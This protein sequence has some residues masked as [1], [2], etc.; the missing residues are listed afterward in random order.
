MADKATLEKMVEQLKSLSKGEGELCL[1]TVEKIQILINDMSEQLSD[2]DQISGELLTNSEAVI[3]TANYA[4]N[5]MLADKSFASDGIIHEIIEAVGNVAEIQKLIEDSQNEIILN[6]VANDS[7]E[8]PVSVIDE[9]DLPLMEDFI[10]EAAEHIEA[11]EAGLLDIENEPKNIEAINTVFRSFHTLKGLA[12]FLNLV[13]IGKLSHSAENLLDMA[14]NNQLDLTTA[15]MNVIFE[16]VDMIKEMVESVKDAV[17]GD[18]VI[19]PQKNLE[20]MLAKLEACCKGDDIEVEGDTATNTPAVEE[21]Q[22]AV[23]E[24]ISKGSQV[25]PEDLEEVK[26][27]SAVKKSDADEKVKVSTSRLDKLINMVGELVISHSMVE[28]GVGLNSG[29]SGLEVLKKVSHQGKIVRELQEL[30]ML[31]RMVPI[32][33]VFQKMSR[34]VR[35][36]A[37]KSQKKVT[38]VTHGEETELDR[39]LVDQIA[40]PLVHMIRNSVDHGIESEQERAAAG[41]SA[42]GKVTL[43]AFHKGGNIVIEIQDDG[44]G[45]DKDKILAKAKEKGVV[46]S[47]AE[48][49]ESEIYKLIFHAGFST[50]AKVT[51]ISG[52]GVGMDVVKRNIEALRGRIDISSVKGQGTTFT[53][54]LPL[55]MAIIEGQIVRVG[56]EKY[57]IPIVSIL[58]CIRPEVKDVTTVNGKCEMITTQEGLMPL[59]KL[60]DNFNV[61]ADVKKPEESAVVIVESDSKRCGLMVDELLGQKQV[62]I[63]N[64]GKALGKV[65][66]ISGGAIMGDGKVSLILDIAGLMK[67]LAK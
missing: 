60:G 8:S 59:V 1:E 54:T 39:I 21:K 26:A 58:S 33:G 57:I 15:S 3:D 64:L 31:M 23:V 42:Q 10:T 34:L 43:K 27:V 50:A 36:L 4:L 44:K 2:N 29:G 63:K 30:S 25:K 18:M 32:R 65:A 56:S 67:V 19:Q 49:S 16:S 35:D 5:T 45:L 38:L 28:Q 48:P 9:D 6:D 41:K 66:G 55:T 37:Q 46:D 52:R 11:G 13:E 20:A 22:E 61:E 12:G 40:D 53:I 17:A 14:R 62:V 24:E 7:A 51:A 47:N